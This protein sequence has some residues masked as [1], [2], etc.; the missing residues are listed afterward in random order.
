MYFTR[1]KREIYFGPTHLHYVLKNPTKYQ[2]CSFKTWIDRVNKSNSNASIT[3][4][5][6]ASKYTILISRFQFN[7]VNVFSSAVYLFSLILLLFALH[8]NHMMFIVLKGIFQ[9]RKTF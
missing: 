4:I 7:T 6:E 9:K 2:F 3:F 5:V 8:K 1:S